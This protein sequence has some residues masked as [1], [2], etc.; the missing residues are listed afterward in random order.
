MSTNKALIQMTETWNSGLDFHYLVVVLPTIEL[1]WR[2]WT[3]P[4]FPILHPEF[5]QTIPYRGPCK[6]DYMPSYTS[7]WY[8]NYPVGL[9]HAL[10]FFRNPD[11]ALKRARCV[12]EILRVAFQRAR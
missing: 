12:R 3:F 11:E 6:L 8:S 9:G 5:P 1:L 2:V 7:Q 10:P 4:T